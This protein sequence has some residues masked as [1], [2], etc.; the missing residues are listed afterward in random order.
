M[1]ARRWGGAEL[2]PSGTPNLTAARAEFL[3]DRPPL[4]VESLEQ[5]LRRLLPGAQLDESTPGRVLVRLE[6]REVTGWSVREAV[7]RAVALWG[8]R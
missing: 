4:A 7:E 2:A 1:K 8:G 3:A 5:R 6:G